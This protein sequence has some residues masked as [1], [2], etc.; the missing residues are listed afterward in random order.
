[1]YVV[2]YAPLGRETLRSIARRLLAS[3]LERDGLKRRGLE[4][5][6]DESVIE[7]LARAG[8]DPTLGARPMKRA[9]EAHVL[10]PLAERLARGEGQ[11]GGRVRM[12]AHD[13]VLAFDGLG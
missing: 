11:R 7:L 10:V 12:R 5:E 13:G 6:A 9:I 2:P 4:V 1:D 3:A 8:F